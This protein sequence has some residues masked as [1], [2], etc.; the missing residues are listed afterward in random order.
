MPTITVGIHTQISIAVPPKLAHFDFGE[1]P[2]NA[3][4]PAS[5]Q[6]TILDGDYPVQVEWLLNGRPAEQL[7]DVSIVQLGKRVTALTVD[8]V[9]GHHR[10]NYTCRVTNVAGRVEQTAGL[11]VNGWC[12]RLCLDVF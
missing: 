1:E 5:V 4:E 7:A 9:A 11:F 6:C 12:D 10:G 3:G 2:L 8:S